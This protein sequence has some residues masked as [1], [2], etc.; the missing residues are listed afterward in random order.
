MLLPTHFGPASGSASDSDRGVSM[1]EE[2]SSALELK[3]V[4][5]E[6]SGKRDSGFAREGN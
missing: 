4:L 6:V 3:R 1:G 2:F 5:R